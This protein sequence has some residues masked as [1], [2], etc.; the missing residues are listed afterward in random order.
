M[1]TSDSNN[2][3]DDEDDDNNDDNNVDAGRISR[4]RTRD[5]NDDGQ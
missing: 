3:Y 1:R 5:E 2:N 4:T